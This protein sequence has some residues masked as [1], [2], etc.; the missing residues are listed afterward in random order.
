M[1]WPEMIHLAGRET[2]ITIEGIESP[3]HAFDITQCSLWPACSR[4]EA[5]D[6]FS[7]DLESWHLESRVIKAKIN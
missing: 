7:G 2:L 6:F 4:D 1:G 3:R 5:R